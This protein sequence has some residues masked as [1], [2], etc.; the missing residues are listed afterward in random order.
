MY[1]RRAHSLGHARQ[2]VKLLGYALLVNSLALLDHFR[3]R[4]EPLASVA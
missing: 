3:R 2:H 4:L 1:L